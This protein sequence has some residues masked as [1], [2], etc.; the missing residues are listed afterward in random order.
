MLCIIHL[1]AL[2]HSN[3]PSCMVKRCKCNRI[4]DK[5]VNYVLYIW[6]NIME[7]VT[8]SLQN[9]NSP[10]L[11]NCTSLLI[12]VNIVNH[13]NAILPQ[14]LCEYYS[15]LHFIAEIDIIY[16]IYATLQQWFYQLAYCIIWRWLIL[17]ALNVSCA[18]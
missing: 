7:W 1:Y 18:E 15:R 4:F 16:I 3:F 5:L 14:I 2:D 17:S 11:N 12:E 13:N 6:N 10:A 8:V 9:F